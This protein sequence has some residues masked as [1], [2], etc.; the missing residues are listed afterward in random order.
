MLLAGDLGGTKSNLGIFEMRQ[1]KLSPIASKRLTSHEYESAEDLVSG[2]V[3]E[4]GDKISGA[5]FAVAGPIVNNVGYPP[6][7]PWTVDGD[8]LARALSI[9]RAR[10]LNDLEATA[11]GIGVLETS[12]FEIIH[13][14]I[15]VPQA[16]KALI[17]AGTGL[18]EAILFWD[19]TRYI[20]RASEGGHA[21][22]APR[23]DQEIALWRYLKA[24]NEFVSCEIILSGRGFRVIH[25][26]LDPDA[27]HSVFDKPHEDAAPLITQQGLEKTCAVCVA[28]LDLWTEMYGAEAGNLAVRTMARGGIY[29]AGGIAVKILP[30]LRD[31]RFAAALAAKEKVGNILA[32]IPIYVVLNEDAPLLGAAHVASL[33]Q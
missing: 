8:K 16:T 9:P 12:A 18:G 26:F 2:F 24:R 6:N 27:R 29:V 4:A 32:Q 13:A 15:P 5:C 30:K 17:A 31:G 10:L 7:L 20:P 33:A 1:G 14:G 22:F 28:T 21:D 11:Y 19:G 3:R 25:E 23:N